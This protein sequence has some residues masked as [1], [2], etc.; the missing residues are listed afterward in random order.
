MQLCLEKQTNTKKIPRWF[1]K[2]ISL[3]TQNNPNKQQIFFALLEPMTGAGMVFDLDTNCPSWS[4]A[5][6]RWRTKP[7]WL[8]ESLSYNFI[9]INWL[10]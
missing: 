9:G 4:R 2:F 1:V 6:M 10:S 5:T 8:Y 7:Q 3:Q